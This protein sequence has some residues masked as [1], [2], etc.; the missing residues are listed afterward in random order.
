MP[1][2][3]ATH[4]RPIRRPASRSRTR[5]AR[6]GSRRSPSTAG[7]RPTNTCSRR[8]A[9]AWPCSTTTATA[10]STSFFVNGTTLE[11]FPQAARSRRATCIATGGDGTFEDV[12][13][14]AGVGAERLGTG[15]VR[16]RLRQR[17]PR[18]SLRHLLGAEPPVP[19]PRRR[20]VRGR[21]RP[22][23][24]LQSTQ[25]PLGRRLRVPRLRP[26]RP[27]R[28]LRR[29][30]HRLRSRRRR[31]CPSRGCAATRA[32]RSRAARP[33]LPGRQERALPQHAA[34]ARSRTSRSASGITRARGTYGLGVSTLDFDDDGWIDLYVANDSNPSA[35]Y[36]N[37]HDGTFTDIAVDAGCAYSQDGK[38]QAGMGVADRRLRSQRHDGHLQ[39]ELR[40]RHVDAVREH[41]QGPV[42]GPHVRERH[43]PQH[44]LAR[45]G[46]RLPR[47][48]QRRLARSVP[49][50]RPRL[51]GGRASEDRGGLQAAQGRLSQSAATDG[52]RTSPSGSGRR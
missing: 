29:Q 19:Q 49:R 17:R 11:G 50:Q 10:G 41:R 23:A 46:R 24:G 32:C 37:N 8:P 6:P 39:D 28:S 21:H 43:R 22:R 1:G 4:I 9:A 31:P 47:S 2:V 27:A 42:R 16:R 48:R 3:S 7:R 12:T 52:S 25:A 35:L 5:R 33:G 14:R 26:R 40:R 44:A 13:A 18:R 20:H 51:S 38:P 34:T 45:L 30:L 36:R 15:R